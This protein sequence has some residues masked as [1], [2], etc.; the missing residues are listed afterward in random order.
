MLFLLNMP[1]EGSLD[2]PTDAS[3]LD[4]EIFLQ[5]RLSDSSVKSNMFCPSLV[6]LYTFLGRS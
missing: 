6:N 4:G 3:G 5:I 1:T 2:I